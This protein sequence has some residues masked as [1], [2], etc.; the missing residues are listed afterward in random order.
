M[1]SMQRLL[2]EIEA[3]LAASGM[4]Q[5]EFGVRADRDRSLMTRLRQGRQ[6]TLAKADRIIA[7]MRKNP[8]AKPA[9]RPRRRRVASPLSLVA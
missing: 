8:P 5:T 2:A 1:N 3:Y 7:Y 4:G 6:V 9:K